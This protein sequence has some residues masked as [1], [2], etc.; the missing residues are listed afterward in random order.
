MRAAINCSERKKKKMKMTTTGGMF[1]RQ[2]NIGAREHADG[3]IAGAPGHSQK[4]AEDHGKN[5]C[6][7]ADP[8]CRNQSLDEDVRDPAPFLFVEAQ[9]E[10]RESVP[11][12]TCS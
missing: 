5:A 3:Q 9:Q 4:R 12:A 6:V 7:N 11:S 10:I 1:R 2:F 8:D